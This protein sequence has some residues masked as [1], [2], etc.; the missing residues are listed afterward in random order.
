ME[1]T[2]AINGFERAVDL[3][4]VREVADAFRSFDKVKKAIKAQE[5]IL[6]PV[7][8]ANRV[9]EF[10]LEDEEKVAFK[11]GAVTSTIDTKKLFKEIGLKKFMEVATVSESSLKQLESELGKEEFAKVL[12]KSKKIT[13][14]KAA[15]VSVAKMTKKELKEMKG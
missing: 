9:N 10:F 14:T 4:K 6:K 7:L 12:S 15:S 8:V 1:K 5:E 11:E 2:V 13:G 3:D